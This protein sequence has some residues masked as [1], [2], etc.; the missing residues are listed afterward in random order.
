MTD[1]TERERAA[2]KPGRWVLFLR[3]FVLYQLWRFLWIN[4]RMYRM[5][6]LS[7]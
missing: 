5:T 6:R 4:V 1:S 2:M 3:T 7:R